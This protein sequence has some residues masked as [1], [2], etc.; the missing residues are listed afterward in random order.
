VRPKLNLKKLIIEN[1][2]LSE[3]E[4]FEIRPH[5]IEFRLKGAGKCGSLFINILIKNIIIE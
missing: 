3:E 1:E 2:Y 5:R 4:H